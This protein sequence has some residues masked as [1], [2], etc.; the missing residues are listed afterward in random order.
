MPVSPA[1]A[2]ASRA[3]G[4]RSRG[5][6]TAEGK[7]RARANALRHGLRARTLAVTRL[8]REAEAAGFAAEIVASLAPAD[9]VQLELAQGI[10]ESFWRLRRVGRMEAEVLDEAAG[11]PS[12]TGPLGLAVV[13]DGNG[14]RAL[15]TV[16]RYRAQASGELGRNL[17]LLLA[18]RAEGEAGA[19]DPGEPDE[20]STNDPDEDGTNEPEGRASEPDGARAPA[21]PAPWAHAND[22]GTSE[23]EAG[24]RGPAGWL[25]PATGN[26]TNEPEAG[27]AGAVDGTSEPEPAHAA[28]DTN[29]PE[30][31]RSDDLARP[32]SPGASC[33]RERVAGRW[34]YLAPDELG[35]LGQRHGAPEADE[36]DASLLE[37]LRASGYRIWTTARPSPSSAT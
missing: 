34:R 15:D 30:A 10:A 23:P 21:S 18:L 19:P 17:R 12:Q 3:N 1:R 2:A 8:E 9:P 36:P 37:D 6:V 14:P 7:A 35:R 26:G 20:G 13:R 5:P 32:R 22:N 11:T 16:I 24:N 31:I 25:D 28:G 4:A 29:E 27:T 33:R